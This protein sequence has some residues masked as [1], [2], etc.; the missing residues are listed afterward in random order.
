MPEDIEEDLTATQK[1]SVARGQQSK[2]DMSILES[3]T[4]PLPDV[5]IPETP[6]SPSQPTITIVRP[7][8]ITHARPRQVKKSD[9]LNAQLFQE[10]CRQIYLSVFF[11]EHNPVRSLG[12]TSSIGGEGKSL[13]SVVTA[14]ALAN[15]S[16]DPVALLEC[17]W[18]HPTLHES[19]GCS[20]S[21]GLAEWLR[22]ECSKADI[23]YQVGDNL[24][25]IPAG[26]GKKDAVKLLRYIKQQG[27]LNIL[28][29]SNELFIVD[30]PSI[31]TTAYGPLAANL[32]ESLIV[33]VQAGVTP[34][35]LVAET[36]TKLENLP[37]QGMILNQ[38]ESR[39]PRWIRQIL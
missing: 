25:F 10:R 13:L 18:D 23:G 24:T 14:K 21:P 20:L 6:L 39:I 29:R 36:C 15:D 30:L 26:N 16:S 12:F 38:L 9:V 28:A 3:Q 17:N 22:G 11:R 35:S 8:H 32:V 5:A 19:F 31:V 4:T 37:V 7:K 2:S 1:I 33:V 27:L 34:G